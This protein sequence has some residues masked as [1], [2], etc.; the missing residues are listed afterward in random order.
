MGQEPYPDCL[1]LPGC[2]GACPG[3]VPDCPGIGLP[4]SDVVSD[5]GLPLSGLSENTLPLALQHIQFLSELH[6]VFHVAVLDHL[7]SLAEDGM[8]LMC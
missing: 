7:V 5:H 6:L 1:V 4:L 3:D 8:H 2:A